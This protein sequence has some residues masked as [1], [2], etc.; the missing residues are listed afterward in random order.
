MKNFFEFGRSKPIDKPKTSDNIPPMKQTG[1]RAD[2]QDA[3]LETEKHPEDYKRS[4]KALQFNLD[5]RKSVK[6]FVT[7]IDELHQQSVLFT[8]RQ[9]LNLVWVEL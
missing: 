2:G 5:D 4:V 6:R 8:L 7:L 3:P 9:D 1:I